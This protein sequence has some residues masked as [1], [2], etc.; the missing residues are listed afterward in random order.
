MADYDFD[1]QIAYMTK[2]IRDAFT[3]AG[4]ELLGQLKA[5]GLI[6]EEQPEVKVPEYLD[7]IESI[8]TDP[9][10]NCTVV[11]FSNGHVLCSHKNQYAWSDAFPS[12]REDDG[13]EELSWLPVHRSV[14]L[15]L[16]PR[17]ADGLRC[18]RPYGHPMIGH[19]CNLK[20]A[21]GELAKLHRG[22]DGARLE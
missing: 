16:H 15:C 13:L 22:K 2:Q 6:E 3:Q 14:D 1:K 9:M 7:L 4:T 11:E 21:E 20:L 12:L 10:N 19:F 5:A 8:H 18:S 17:D